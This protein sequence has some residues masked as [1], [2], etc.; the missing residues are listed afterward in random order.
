MLSAGDGVSLQQLQLLPL[1]CAPG[2]RWPVTVAAVL[3]CAEAL[4]ASLQAALS[5]AA[6]VAAASHQRS[7]LLEDLRAHLHRGATAQVACSPCPCIVMS[8]VNAVQVLDFDAS[9][10]L[11]AAGRPCGE[12]A[13]EV[14]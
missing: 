12:Q 2:S 14:L 4:S 1:W 11:N 3:H 6:G 8:T 13:P 7:S 10:W 5:E 9:A